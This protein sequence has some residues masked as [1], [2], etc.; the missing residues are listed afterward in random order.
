MSDLRAGELEYASLKVADIVLT[1]IDP[2]P[3]RILQDNG[4]AIHPV[5]GGIQITFP[6][7]SIR[8]RLMSGMCDH[9]R[10]TLPSGLKI[11]EI[12][13]VYQEMTQL[14]LI[15]TKAASA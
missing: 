12:Y 8:V 15:I 5:A 6:A 10:I 2:E 7:G 14:V 1:T 3:C 4:C 9:F 13:D 11:Q